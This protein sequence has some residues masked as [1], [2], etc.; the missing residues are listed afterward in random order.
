MLSLLLL[1]EAIEG[2][3][4]IQIQQTAYP[5]IGLNQNS[6]PSALLLNSGHEL[7][8]DATVQ[9]KW[10]GNGKKILQLNK[11]GFLVKT[12]ATSISANMGWKTEFSD[13][14]FFSMGL[15]KWGNYEVCIVVGQLGSAEP[16][17]EDCQLLT[18]SPTTPPFLISPVHK[19]EIN[20]INPMLIWQGPAP[21]SGTENLVYQLK[22]VKVEGN[23]SEFEAIK[24]NKAI[25]QELVPSK[26]SLQYPLSAIS[27]QYNQ[28]YAWQVK[29]FQDKQE[30][31]ATEIW[32]FVPRKDSLDALRDRVAR[33]SFSKM[34]SLDKAPLIKV[35]KDLSV[36]IDGFNPE[37]EGLFSIQDEKGRTIVSLQPQSIQNL[38]SGKIILDLSNYRMN[39]KERYK[40]S[41]ITKDKLLFL[42]F[43][44]SK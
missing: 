37:T 6:F 35:G 44:T 41:Y 12:G 34:E 9:V 4:Q 11:K 33:L 1:L 28:W 30:I 22:V 18:S 16:L 24:R 2:F 29:V 23:Q 5:E 43:Q 31:A 26:T 36:E 17:A 25:F 7:T 3:S 10:R 39:E 13:P 8:V 27:L 15:L 20:T 14:E 40:L 21:L 19:E 32:K 42:F 38:G